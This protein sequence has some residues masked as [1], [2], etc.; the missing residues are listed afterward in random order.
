MATNSE[1]NDSYDPLKDQSRR[2]KSNDPE[3]KY[4][5]Y[6]ETG[7]RE[8]IQCALCPKQIKGGI[9]RVKQHLVGGYGDIGPVCFG[10]WQLLATKSCCGLPNGQLFSQLL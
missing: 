5:Y 2:P 8:L 6:V 3:W 7:K 4:A 10:F 1:A 9:K